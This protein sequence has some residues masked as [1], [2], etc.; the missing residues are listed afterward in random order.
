M[1]LLLRLF[2]FIIPL[3]SYSQNADSIWIRQNYN[4][5]EQYITMRDGVRLFTSIYTPKDNTEKHPILLTRTPYSCAPYGT[6]FKPFWQTF[7]KEYF[8]EKYIMVLQDVRGR[9]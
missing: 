5:T 2:L 3:S 8:K 4:K 6:D 1:K 9:W 7:Y